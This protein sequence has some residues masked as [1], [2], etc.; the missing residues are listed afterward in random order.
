M[1]D[2]SIQWQIFEWQDYRKVPLPKG[3]YEWCTFI[4]CDISNSD[5]SHVQFS[6]C[7]F[8]GCNLSM[9]KM[10]ATR[11]QNITF[12]D[13]KM[14]GV[15]FDTCN[16]FLIEFSFENCVLNYSSFFGMKIPKTV[17]KNSSIQEVNFTGAN[18]NGA[19]F[20]N[21]DLLK[22]IFDR[23]YLVG[24]DF[25]SS[26]WYLIDPEENTLTEARFSLSGTP[27]LLMKYDIIIE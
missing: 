27:G 22:A 20:E 26:Y 25:T 12:K 11:L 17:F 14:L 10:M 1:P 6:D 16:N 13:S 7:E 9:T 15:Q 23:T 21:C 24:V 2:I 8:T 18:L 5:L 19:I 3:E 4:R